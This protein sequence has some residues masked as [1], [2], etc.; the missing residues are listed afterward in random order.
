MGKN[1]ILAVDFGTSNS[2]AGASVDGK[3]IEALPLDLTAQ[4][5][6]LMRSILF[7][8]NRD[9]CFYGS[10]AIEKYLEGELEGRIFR[11]F[12]SHLPNRSYLGTAIENRVLPLEDLIGLFLLEI[13]RRAEK[14]LDSEI[15]TVLLGRPAQYSA[16]PVADG[17][18]IH[19]MSK[20]AEF[21]K[22][23]HI[24]FMPE[25]LAAALDFRRQLTAEKIVLVG[26]FGGGT[27]DFTLIRIGP[28]AHKK[29]NVLG[30]AGC[31][32]AGD[33]LDSLFM[34]HRL[35]EF[36]GAKAHYKMLFG[37]NL[38]TMPPI[39]MER[40]NKPAH[41]VHLREK[42]TYEFIKEVRKGTQSKTDQEAIDRLLVLVDDQQIFSL[43]EKIETTKRELSMQSKSNLSFDYPGIEISCDF[44]LGD[45]ADWS[46][47]TKE[48]IFA[49]LDECLKQA[50]LKPEQVDLVC[51]TGGSA[52]VKM[53]R[54][55]FVQRFGEDRLQTQRHFH[56]VLS[57][58]IE[59]AHMVG[60]GLD[61]L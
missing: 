28:F 47:D 48:K 52:Q 11:S 20:A 26:D 14:I 5:P 24:H 50:S 42:A 53:I 7:F 23:K 38:L 22:F 41:I 9:Q 4:D 2:L 18:A 12:K 1:L 32:L 29:E 19:R 36:F 43:F 21:A 39:I 15:D 33:A 58:L 34:S 17:F 16:D 54:D 30:L 35:N 25:P 10:T 40:L 3:R 59:G 55:E 60:Q 13:K 57:G 46:H 45:F 37:S 6:T 8:P 51:L 49:S 56:S 61:Y 27:S 31:A 44:S